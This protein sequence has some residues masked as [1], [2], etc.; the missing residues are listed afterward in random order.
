MGRPVRQGATYEDLC[1]VPEH[2]IAELING[3]LYTSPLLPPR[4]AHAA[5][6]LG[7]LIMAP[8]DLTRRGPGSWVFLN[9][10]ELHWGRDVLVPDI[11]G[12][13]RERMPRIPDGVG[14]ELPPDWV[15]EVLSPTTTAH[16]RAR[17]MPIYLRAGVT[18]FWLIDPVAQTVEIF[19][20]QS[21]C[22]SLRTTLEGEAKARIEP[23][24]A[25]ELDLSVLWQR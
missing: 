1:A 5:S 22:W 8:F 11:A 9:K 23:F 17:K 12:W 10:P 2:L 19:R 13:R 7:F 24:D 25:I 18:H 6:R 4:H 20:S 3:D 14:I 15:C 16:D 21:G